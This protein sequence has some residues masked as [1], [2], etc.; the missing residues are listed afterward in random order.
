MLPRV[1]WSNLVIEARGHAGLSQRA[2]ARRAG[3]PPSTVHRIEAER[4]SPTVEMFDRLLTAAG[5]EAAVTLLPTLD[6]VIARPDLNES[7]RRSLALGVLTA[8]RVLTEPLAAI[9]LARRN[10]ATMRKASTASSVPY[11]HAWEQLLEGPTTG[12]VNV[13]VGD[14]QTARDL[15][16]AT[17]FAGLVPEPERRAA[18]RRLRAAA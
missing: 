8:R 13:L 6:D 15:R 16:Q 14:D 9:A 4:I 1:K 18:I 11:L 10:L 2:L 7:E 3:V 5:V 12:L 17:P